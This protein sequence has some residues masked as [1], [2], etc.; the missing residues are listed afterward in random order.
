LVDALRA[1]GDPRLGKVT[2]T[3]VEMTD[4]LQLARIYVRSGLDPRGGE[5]QA[6]AERQRMMRGLQAASGRLRAQLGRGLALRYTP[7]LRFFLDEGLEAQTRV[8][9][10]LAEIA[11]EGESSDSDAGDPQSDPQPD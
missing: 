8:D 6:D 2:V 3:R 1:M 9:E 11:T 4:D 10:L 7:S 5:G